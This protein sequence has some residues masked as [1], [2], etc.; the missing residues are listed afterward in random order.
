MNALEMYRSVFNYASVGIGVVSTNGK[1][2]DINNNL[3]EILGYNDDEIS[4]INIKSLV[5]PDDV[6]EVMQN[7]YKIID[8]SL[9]FVHGLKR[10]INSD[11]DIL[12]G[13]LRSVPLFGENNEIIAIISTVIEV[14]GENNVDKLLRKQNDSFSWLFQIYNDNAVIVVDEEMTIIRI[15]KRLEQLLGYSTEII[16]EKRKISEFV[17]IG[18]RAKLIRNHYL[19]RKNIGNI[20]D[21][22]HCRIIYDNGCAYKH[23]INVTLIPGTNY[24]M[25]SLS[26]KLSVDTSEAIVNKSENVFRILA[27]NATDQIFISDLDYNISYI[28][29]SVE[30]ISGY[31]QEEFKL[32]TPKEYMTLSSHQKIVKFQEAFLNKSNDFMK[33]RTME[34]RVVHKN[35]SLIWIETLVKFILTEDGEPIGIIGSSRDITERKEAEEAIRAS[36]ERYRFLMEGLKDVVLVVS[37]DLIIEYISPSVSE[38]CD[39]LPEEITGSHVS[40]YFVIKEEYN[41]LLE[42]FCQSFKKNEPAADCDF[43]VKV[44]NRDNFYIEITAKPSFKDGRIVMIQC[45]ARD[46]SERKKVEK[47]LREHEKTLSIENLTLKK[48]IIKSERFGDIIGKSEAMQNVYELILKAV[49]SNANIVIYGESGTGKELVAHAIHEMSDRSDKPFVVVNCGAIPESIIES[50]FFGYKKGAFTGA[51]KD[52]YGFLDLADGGTLFLD[53]IGEIGLNMQ[54]KLLRAIEGGGYS[55]VGS[56]HIKKPKL[57]IVAAT[58]RNLSEMVIQKKMREDFFFRIHVIPITIPPLRERKNDIPLLMDHFLTKFRKNNVA[59]NI[60]LDVKSAFFNYHWPGNVRELQN[61]LNRYL[62]INEIDFL[63]TYGKTAKDEKSYDLKKNI[64]TGNV[65]LSSMIEKFEKS[66]LEKELEKNRWN[67]SRTAHILNIDRK[68]LSSKIKKYQMLPNH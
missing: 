12:R 43:L 40:K 36:E 53:E 59:D 64:N 28:S 33:I 50:E 44:R 35:G 46:I 68:T 13:D 63:E 67:K 14:T 31:T 57:H 41:K 1:L 11:G 51:F 17:H 15:N 34:L 19:R 66:V 56:N 42:H 29:P 18:D 25:V 5:H 61:A 55:P 27:E 3:R 52:K 10:F 4:K 58:N 23:L 62:A 47:K 22:Y 30:R 45:V 49:P 65:T 48:S 39:Y 37:P 26:E 54:V 6:E 38:F 20:P 16:D 21:Q 8:G 32:L 24:S 60:P 7:Y 2:I 9:P